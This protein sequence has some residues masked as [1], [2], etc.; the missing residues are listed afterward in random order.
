MRPLM[1][2]PSDRR[3]TKDVM[4]CLWTV[5]Q[6]QE[7]SVTGQVSR[8]LVRSGGVAKQVLTPRKVAAVKNGEEESGA[9]QERH[10]ERTYDSDPK[11]PLVPV[12]SS[13]TWTT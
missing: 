5:E 4:R 13:Q 1:K 10:E 3:F 9:G 6:L 2:L 11:E 12:A 8:R 7:R